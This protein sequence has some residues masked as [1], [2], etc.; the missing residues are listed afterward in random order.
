[1]ANIKNSYIISN[2]NRKEIIEL[3]ARTNDAQ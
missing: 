1:M 3:E 2:K